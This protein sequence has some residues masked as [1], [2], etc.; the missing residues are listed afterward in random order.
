MALHYA[1]QS[2]LSIRAFY[3]WNTWKKKDT[4][5]ES[6]GSNYLLKKIPFHAIPY[7]LQTYKIISF[8]VI[9]V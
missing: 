6:F 7:L 1:S 3:L 2:F 9:L 4:N 8:K 5:F